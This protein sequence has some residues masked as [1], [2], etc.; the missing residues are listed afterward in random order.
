MSAILSYDYP[1]FGSAAF[2]PYLSRAVHNALQPNATQKKTY[3]RVTSRM[4]PEPLAEAEPG[5]VDRGRKSPPA[6]AIDHEL[7]AV[8]QSAIPR[9][10]KPQQRDTAAWVVEHIL[11]TGE[12]PTL[13]EIARVQRPRVTHQRAAQIIEETVN[14]LGRQIEADYPQLAEDGVGGWREFKKVFTRP[15]PAGRGAG[16]GKGRG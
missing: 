11:A 3:E 9:L 4:R 13:Q 15:G 1:R 8:V 12:R 10:P 2:T 14:S 7:L 5:G 6:E 16:T